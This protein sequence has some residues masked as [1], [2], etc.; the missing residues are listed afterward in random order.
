[1]SNVKVTVSLPPNL[2]E[3]TDKTAEKQETNRSAVI[4][5]A[6]KNYPDVY[7]EWVKLQEAET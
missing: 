5:A 7:D 6:L 2:L 3:A 4:Q 1:M